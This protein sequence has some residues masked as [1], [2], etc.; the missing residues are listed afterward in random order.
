[1]AGVHWREKI[2]SFPCGFGP[3]WAH[4]SN[5]F[6]IWGKSVLYKRVKRLI[7]LQYGSYDTLLAYTNQQ[8]DIFCVIWDILC[9]M[10]REKFARNVFCS[11]KH[12]KYIIFL[13]LVYNE[14][15]KF[16]CNV[17]RS[18]KHKK[19]IRCFFPGSYE[20]KKF[21]WNKNG[22]C[23]IKITRS[24][25]KWLIYSDFAHVEVKRSY[26]TSFWKEKRS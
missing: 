19:T 16:I 3:R 7:Q 10:P 26:V 21:V 24:N 8:W 11:Y 23:N 6:A 9:Y 18:Y 25:H 22:A 1:M 13:F 4:M 5:P 15:K 12:T 2:W 20:R 14:P 17:F